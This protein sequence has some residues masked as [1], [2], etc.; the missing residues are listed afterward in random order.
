MKIEPIFVPVL[1][2]FCLNATGNISS[3]QLSALN[4]IGTTLTFMICAGLL[5]GLGIY[6]GWK[7]N[8]LTGAAYGYLFSRFVYL[9]QDL[10]AIR[11]IKAEG[12]LGFRTWKALAL[13]GLIATAFAGS[14]LFLPRISFWLLIPAFAHG[15]MVAAWLLRN[16]LKKLLRASLFSSASRAVPAPSTKP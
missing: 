1:A 10:F 2:A 15:S 8:G 7:V 5:A 14:Y 9:A 3:S 13:Q 11:L 16:P 4:R 6:A 12:W